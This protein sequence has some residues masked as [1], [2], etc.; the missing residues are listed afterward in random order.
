[1]VSHFSFLMTLLA[2]VIPA[3]QRGESEPRPA[4]VHF[5]IRIE[6][7]STM[8]TLK[9]SNGT[10]APAPTAPVLWVVHTNEAPIFSTGKADRGLGLET[11][12]EDGNPSRLA[13]AL[14]GRPGIVAV[15]FVNMPIGATEPGPI[16]PGAAYDLGFT[17]EPG[18]RLTI[19]MMFG[20]SNDLF[21]APD[22]AGIMLF[23]DKSKPVKGDITSRLILW[24]AGT[25][26]NQE[27]GLG[28]DQAPRQKADNIGTTESRPVD[29]VKDRFNY[30]SVKDVVRVTVT[31]HPMSATS[32]RD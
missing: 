12:A 18:Q 20:Q 13:A 17:A 21:Y 23:D 5:S 4:A 6:N 27:P 25:E 29:R 3:P 16:L 9:L 28:P 32:S 30:P 7:V 1:M 8:K 15:G 31:P 14:E 11:L 22:A 24:D 26:V 19:A 10:T 2:A